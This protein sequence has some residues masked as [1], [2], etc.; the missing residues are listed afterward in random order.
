MRGPC[1]L[2]HVRCSFCGEPTVCR[3]LRG[4]GPDHRRWCEPCERRY[5]MAGEQDDRWL[6]LSVF[7]LSDVLLHQFE[8]GWGLHIITPAAA[9]WVDANIP[10]P[11]WLMDGDRRLGVLVDAYQAWKFGN[12]MMDAGLRVR[13]GW[14]YETFGGQ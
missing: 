13:Q 6:P 7:V 12:A 4:F 10:Q 11:R 3:C 1:P 5:V 2:H 8:S 9:A 14:S